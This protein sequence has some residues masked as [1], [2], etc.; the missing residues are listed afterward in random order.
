MMLE[1]LGTRVLIEPKLNSELRA[2]QVKASSGLLLATSKHEGQPKVGR[3]V[4]I[5][6]KVDR[7]KVDDIVVFSELSPEG[8]KWEGVGYLW[9]ENENILAI[10]HD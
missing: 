4:A 5:G 6:R 2:E 7:C 9:S 8:I 3:V 10:W 1:P